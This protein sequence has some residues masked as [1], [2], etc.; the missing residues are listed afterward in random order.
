MSLK[1]EYKFIRIGK[2]FLWP[3]E[4]AE[5]K[6]KSIIHQYAQDG[7]RL[8]QIFAPSIGIYGLSRFYEV[9]LERQV[10]KS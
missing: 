8:V 7:W 4:E 1:Y 10:N 6:Y 2:G 9:I 3:K 5:K